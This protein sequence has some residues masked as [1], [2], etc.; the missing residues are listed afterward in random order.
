MVVLGMKGSL[1]CCVVRINGINSVKHCRLAKKVLP[2]ASRLFG[3]YGRWQW[4]G[5]ARNLVANRLVDLS[6]WLGGVDVASRDF[7]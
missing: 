4:D 5:D 7:K 6:G 1:G 3:V 2:V